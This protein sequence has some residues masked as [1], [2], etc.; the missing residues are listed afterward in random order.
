MDYMLA[1]K[2]AIMP[3]ASASRRPEPVSWLRGHHPDFLADPAGFLTRCAR[4]YGDAVPL[5]FGPVRF[6]VLSDPVRIGEVLT[7]KAGSFC[8]DRGIQR[9]RVLLGNGLLLSE[10]AEHDRK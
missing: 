9:T 4:D 5:R 2:E 1:R 3:A 6:W 10:G 7:T 8:K